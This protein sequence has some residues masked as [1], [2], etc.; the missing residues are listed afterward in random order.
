MQMDDGDERGE[1]A[2]RTVAVKERPNWGKGTMMELAR[3]DND[4]WG[5]IV[6]ERARVVMKLQMNGPHKQSVNHKVADEKTT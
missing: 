2:L 6:H 3:N 4:F 5:P 1:R